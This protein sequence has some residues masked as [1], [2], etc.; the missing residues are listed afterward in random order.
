MIRICALAILASTATAHAQDE[1]EIQVYDVET[2][3]LGE[4]GL[5]LHLNQHLIHGAPDETHLTFEPHVGLQA[6]LELGG[7]VQTAMTTTGELA[8]AGVKV[9]LKARWPRRVWDER[10]GLAANVEISDV[11]AR[12]EANRWGGELRP[13]VDLVSGRLYVAVNPIIG[14]DLRGPRAGHL[15]LEPALKVACILSPSVMVGIEGYGALGPVDDLGSERV[16]RGFGVV[17]VK[18]SWWDLDLGLGAS[19]GTPDHPIGKLI[20]GLHPF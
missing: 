4:A 6:W 12:F 3:P 15:K 9:R 13:V 18:G 10:L 7:Y 20:F 8:Y 11:P 16:E 1:F 14:F 5:E 19:W 2:A 17:D